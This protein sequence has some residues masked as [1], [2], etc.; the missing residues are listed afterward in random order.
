MGKNKKKIRPQDVEDIFT[1]SN[2]IQNIVGRRVRFK[3]KN[4]IQK[5]FAKLITDKEIIIAAGPAGTGKSFVSI[6]R[7][8]ELLQN[9]TNKFE[10]LLIYKPAIEVEEK[11]GFLPGD[12]NEKIAPYVES[13]LAI[14]DKIIGKSAR[15]QMVES[16]IIEIKAL[17]YIRGMNIDNSI[18]IMEEGQNMS[19]NQMKTLLSRIGENSKFIIS[20]DMDQ[21][22]RYRDIKKSGLYDAMHRLKDMDEIGFLKFGADDIVRN[23]I[24]G[25]ILNYY[26]QSEPSK[27]TTPPK[28]NVKVNERNLSKKKN[29][30][31]KTTWWEKLTKYFKW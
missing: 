6:A 1:V 8:L 11:H 20:G 13:S 27:K 22:D 17:A 24:I 7:G 16:G 4:Q 15:E 18:L 3:A 21:S 31:S 28:D 26:N 9:K 14:V 2:T 25:K 23:P 30:Q 5:E 12:L 29:K 19:I 10:K